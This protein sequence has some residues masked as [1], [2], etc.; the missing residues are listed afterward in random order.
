MQDIAYYETVLAIFSGITVAANNP[1]AMRD[2]ADVV[3]ATQARLTRA[4]ESSPP[5][6]EDPAT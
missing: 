2:I 5:A 4:R 6:L 3:E 1:Q